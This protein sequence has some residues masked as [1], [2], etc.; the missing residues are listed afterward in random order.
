MKFTGEAPEPRPVPSGHIPGSISLPA[1]EVLDPATQTVLRGANISSVLSAAGIDVSHPSIIFSCGS[2]V[3][4]SA[5]WLATV[6]ARMDVA[7]GSWEQLE[8]GL[9]IYDGSWTEWAQREKDGAV[10]ERG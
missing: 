7:P 5:V 6:V 10:L 2:G 8:D 3:Q 9:S 4:A 1:T